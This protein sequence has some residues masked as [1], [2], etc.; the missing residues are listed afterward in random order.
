MPPGFVYSGSACASPTPFGTVTPVPLVDGA[1]T[2]FYASTG[3][4]ESLYGTFGVTDERTS[5]S[6]AALAHYTQGVTL[7]GQIQPLCASGATPGNVGCADLSTPRIIFLFIGFSNCDVEICGGHVDAW[8]ATRNQHSL[9]QL[10]GQACATKC[11][12]LGNPDAVPPYNVAFRNGVSDGYDQMSFIRQVY[13]PVGSS[14][15]GPSVVVFDGALGAQTLDKWDP[16]SI[17]YYWSNDCDYD[18]FTSNDP[19]CNYY[20]VADDLHTNGFTEAQVQAVFVKSGDSFPT[21]DLQHNFCP[22]GT[23]PDAYQ[24]ET[25]LG[26]IMRYLKCCKLDAQHHSTGVPRYPNL[27]QVFVTSRTYGGYANATANGNTCLNPEPF[28]YEWG[29]GVQRIITAQIRQVGGITNPSDSYSGEVDYT[30][31]PWFDWGPY[32]W[33]YGTTPRNYDQLVWCNGQ[34]LTQCN[35][36]NE[37]DV[38]YGDLLNPTTYWGDYTHPTGLGVQKVAGQLVNFIKTSP[39][40]TPWIG[41]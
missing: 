1:T 8:D 15:V 29:F 10:A 21:C 5:G 20:R 40:I 34:F 23:L 38:L 22:S 12:N 19:E 28:A 13:P 9:P 31:A 11:P 36:G 2:S 16:T 24:A 25:Y 35:N 4:I 18:R 14:L 17:G 41:D 32:L 30:T 39:W 7:A 3:E 26:N 6:G 27:K 33:A 37:R